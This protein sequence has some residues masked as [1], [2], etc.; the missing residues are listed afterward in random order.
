[1]VSHSHN[2]VEA[3]TERFTVG[4][5][6]GT[7]G[8]KGEVRVVSRTDFPE[9]RFK[10]G[11]RL[12]LSREHHDEQTLVIQSAR[13][14]NRVYIVSF[15]GLSSIEEV[16]GFKGHLLQVSRSDLPT[17]PE[18]EYFIRD[19]IGCQVFGDDEVYLGELVDVLTPG[20]NDVYVVRKTDSPDLLLP[21]IP[22]CILGVNIE[23]KRMDVHV[24]PGLL[25]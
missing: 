18:G 4:A 8:L 11:S 1:M 5:I 19:L 7:H 14:H 23:A 22:S 20:A 9:L 16:S 24:M 12:I 17:L 15:E 13:L 3:V 2:G 25:E 10:K 21:A 6:V